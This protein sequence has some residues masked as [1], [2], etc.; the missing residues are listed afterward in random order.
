MQ[1]FEKIL[2]P[3]DFSNDSAHAVRM[4]IDIAR[5]YGAALTLLHVYQ[6]IAYPM[7]IG[8]AF[9]TQPQ[10][11]RLFESIRNHLDALLV[12]IRSGG[13]SQADARLEQG[14]PATEICESAKQMGYDLIVM[15]TQGR[16]GIAHF[17]VGSV[18]ERVIRMAP[19]PVLTVKTKERE[20]TP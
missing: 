15:G 18:A 6:P 2:V 14:V 9:F 12:E 19:C 17:L 16:T 1:P 4:G 3:V 10:L 11:D 8:H 13:V 7:P 20:L 5:R